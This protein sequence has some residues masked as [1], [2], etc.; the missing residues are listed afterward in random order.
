MITS[1]NMNIEIETLEVVFGF[2][3]EEAEFFVELSDEDKIK[4][5]FERLAKSTEFVSKIA[6]TVIANNYEKL[7]SKQADV[8]NQ[9]SIFIYDAVISIEEHKRI[10]EYMANAKYRQAGSSLR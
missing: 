6:Q 2:T 4:F 10:D 9:K 3:T 7:S 5:D 8:V 1:H